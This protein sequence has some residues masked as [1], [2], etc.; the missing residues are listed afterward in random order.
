VPKKGSRD[1]DPDSGGR[2]RSDAEL[3][4]L[5]ALDDDLARADVDQS[6]ADADQTAS[7]ADQTTA[8]MDTEL[9]DR[10][11]EASNRDQEASD[12]DQV[13]ADLELEQHPGPAS[14]RQH[15]AST[16]DR[17]TGTR[18]RGQT[19]TAR[20]ISA[21]QRFRQAAIRDESA[22]QRDLTAETRDDAAV[23]RDFESERLEQTMASGGASLR[24]ALDHATTVRAQAARDRARA[25]KDRRHAAADR[26]RAADERMGALEELERAHVDDLT[27]ALR[28]G[29]GEQALQWEIDR[30]RRSDGRVVLAFVDV[31]GLR[32][33]NNRYGHPAGD[34][35]LRDV[36]DAIRL[37][38]RSYE[39]IVRFGGDE[40]VCAISDVDLRQAELRFEAIKQGLAMTQT[41]A[42]VS[43]GLAELRPDDTLAELIERAD[44]AL[45]DARQ[46]TPGSG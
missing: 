42:A 12:R 19:A 30:A 21:E 28:R 43:V 27:G 11:Q 46:N 31:D 10:D 4:R 5:A 35:L 20:T 9:A 41:G 29:L 18:A 16:A 15:A 22:R 38:I 25:S 17:Q 8:E 24:A 2:D 3:W 33:V 45:L 13:V 14:T 44:A 32:E 39:P 7:D 23:R 6:A 1:L 37:R 26:Q 34:R 36:V 40:F